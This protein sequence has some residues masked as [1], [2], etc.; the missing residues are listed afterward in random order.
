MQ[1]LIVYIDV[2]ERVISESSKEI[3]FI[4]SIRSI[5]TGREYDYFETIHG[6][7]PRYSWSEYELAYPEVI[8][9]ESQNMF[10]IHII[11][12]GL[13][14][15][16]MIS[17]QCPILPNGQIVGAPREKI[18]SKNNDPSTWIERMKAEVNLQSLWSFPE[19]KMAAR[20]K[21]Q[22]KWFL[23]HL[24][25]FAHPVLQLLRNGNHIAILSIPIIDL[26]F[27]Y[28][29]GYSVHPNQSI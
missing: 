3:D 27:L 23:K 20:T 15:Q 13:P 26:H 12:D 18:L 14:H 25:S 9:K 16:R 11:D 4:R 29:Y 22:T 28:R 19:R 8:P 17:P 24:S 2:E 21:S 6:H 5:Q 10:R 7:K 1:T